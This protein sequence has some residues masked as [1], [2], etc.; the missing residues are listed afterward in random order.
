MAR[1]VGNTSG[2]ASQMQLW[3]E[4]LPQPI[5]CYHPRIASRTGASAASVATRGTGL[6]LAF[7]PRKAVL[8]SDSMVFEAEVRGLIDE[9]GKCSTT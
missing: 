4:P 6:V 9:K 2:P 7:R 8:H 1:L 3:P 5:E